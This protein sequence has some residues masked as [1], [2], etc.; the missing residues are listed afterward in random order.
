MIEKILPQPRK[1]VSISIKSLVDS[2][3]LLIRGKIRMFNFEA[4]KRE[5]L[6]RCSQENR[7]IYVIESGPVNWMVFSSQEV[8]NLRRKQVFKKNLTFIEMEEK[9][10]FVARPKK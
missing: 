4:A 7:K 6:R 5:A 1:I 8:R 9:S 3:K 10:A 2:F